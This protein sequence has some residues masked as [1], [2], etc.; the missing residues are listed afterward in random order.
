MFELSSRSLSKLEGV[1]NKL[2]EVVKYAIQVTDID[3]GVICGLRT[4]EEQ[5]ALVDKGLH[6]Q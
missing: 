2:I 3:F 6:K 4:E 5:R 1:D